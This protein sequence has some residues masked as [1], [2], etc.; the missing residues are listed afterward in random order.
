MDALLDK[1]GT[2]KDNLP[3]LPNFIRA[4]QRGEVEDDIFEKFGP[5]L[6][7]RWVLAMDKKAR[8][9]QKEI[10][11]DNELNES[12]LELYQD[13]RDAEVA[14]ARAQDAVA[15]AAAIKNGEELDFPVDEEMEDEF[16]PFPDE[17][18]NG[19][20]TVDWGEGLVASL[21]KPI[22]ATLLQPWQVRDTDT[23]SPM[24]DEASFWIS[25]DQIYDIFKDKQDDPSEGMGGLTALMET[26]FETGGVS[27]DYV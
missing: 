6:A 27:G 5:A 2:K 20:S 25:K 11:E 24:V 9:K 18:H 23:V 16:D 8:R 10:Y 13:N 21:L 4:V 19:M 7:L 22:D 15:R 3:K 17:P 1:L 12:E 14:I 26:V